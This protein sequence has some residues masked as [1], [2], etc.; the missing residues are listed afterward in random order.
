M[1]LKNKLKTLA[2]YGLVLAGLTFGLN[3]YINTQINNYN[4]KN[5]SG[6]ETI[7]NDDGIYETYRD[8]IKILEH[9]KNLETFTYNKSI[10]DKIQGIEFELRWPDS[11]LSKYAN[12]RALAFN[13]KG[14]LFAGLITLF[15]D[16]GDAL[17]RSSDYG[18]TWAP[19][20]LREYGNW[21]GSPSGFIPNKEVWDI[22]I[23]DSNWIFIGNFPYGLFRSKDNG[24]SWEWLSNRDHGFPD[25]EGNWS[26]SIA[27]ND[28][29]WL[30][31]TTSS[32][33]IFISRNNGDRWGRTIG[34]PGF[35]YEGKYHYDGTK[36][37]VFTH[38]RTFV[39]V[40]KTP[41]FSDIG[42][43]GIYISDNGFIWGRSS[44]RGIT[45]FTGELTVTPNKRYIFASGKKG[46]TLIPPYYYPIFNNIYRSSDDGDS[47][48]IVKRDSVDAWALETNSL[49]H[50]FV[51]G[52]GSYDLT[53]GLYRSIDNGDSWHLLGLYGESVQSITFDDSGYAFVG[54]WNAVYRSVYPLVTS[55]IKP[56][57]KD[58]P[59]NYSLKQNYPNP[60]NPSTTIEFEIPNISYTTLKIFNILGGE[61][62]TLVNK[63]LSP[64]S[65]K[66]NWDAKNLSSGI[67]FYQ[68]KT[69]DYINTKKMLLLK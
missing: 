5:K 9:P 52:G 16:V 29:G 20:R 21:Y 37:P 8:K 19:Q 48:Q 36:S 2:K 38:D 66:V 44:N 45:M 57:D 12:V 69:N 14:E 59:Q 55:V 41:A 31:F 27:I 43:D 64:G 68:L 3:Y 15:S 60:F 32:D 58:L 4:S 39:Y 40:G 47:W 18:K 65:Y 23:N 25:N 46:D 6:L 17:W 30:Y 28:S 49:G 34:I 1:S 42:K 61:L 13:K 22:A 63:E 26:L 67:Y 24:E 56:V 50:I 53:S 51:C 10:S 33:G 11:L 35:W 62:E 54:T 7:V